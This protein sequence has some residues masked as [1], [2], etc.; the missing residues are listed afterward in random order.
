MSPILPLKPLPLLW[1]W[2]KALISLLNIVSCLTAK[3]RRLAASLAPWP[4]CP[5]LVNRHK[6]WALT[7]TV[8]RIRLY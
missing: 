5:I 2:W 7:D 8:L 3:E 4:K 1:A 6:A